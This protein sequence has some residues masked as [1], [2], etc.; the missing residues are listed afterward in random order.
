V[1]GL[2][3]GAM[4]VDVPKTAPSPASSPNTGEEDI[5]QLDQNHPGFRDPVYRQ[6]RN[7]IANRAL[8]WHVGDPVPD[9][10]YN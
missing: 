3:W 7:A 4:P 8:R 9:V 6:R 10:E 1:K 5:V 2:H